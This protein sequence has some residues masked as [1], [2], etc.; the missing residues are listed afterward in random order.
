MLDTASN[1]VL[2]SPSNVTTSSVQVRNPGLDKVVAEFRSDGQSTLSNLV[3]TGSSTL[4]N[5]VVTGSN[6]LSNLVVTGSIT[7]SVSSAPALAAYEGSTIAGTGFGST[8]TTMVNWITR[9][10]DSYTDANLIGSWLPILPSSNLT[11]PASGYYMFL[12]TTYG[13]MGGVLELS[14]QGGWNIVNQLV[15]TSMNGNGNGPHGTPNI[16]YVAQGSNVQ[17]QART[18]TVP[19]TTPRVFIYKL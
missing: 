10:T 19:M 14:V 7:T 13:S 5:L 3:V 11:C 17:I 15:F 2:F 4:S 12:A 1:L 18:G 8:T 16:V 6:T 9:V